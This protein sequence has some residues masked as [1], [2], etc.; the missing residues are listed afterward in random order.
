MY[1]CAINLYAFGPLSHTRKTYCHRNTYNTKEKFPRFLSSLP[2]FSSCL[3][4]YPSRLSRRAKG[5]THH[6]KLERTS[7]VGIQIECSI[8][9]P[10]SYRKED[11][12]GNR[13]ICC[14]FPYFVLAGRRHVDIRKFNQ[15]I[16]R[17]LHGYN[18]L[19]VMCIKILKVKRVNDFSS[20]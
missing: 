11:M 2:T 1:T 18:V 16:R 15:E 19:D 13:I 6:E 9:R 17:V 14:G 3:S 7:P 5:H 8:V 12:R 10:V 4:F 20:E